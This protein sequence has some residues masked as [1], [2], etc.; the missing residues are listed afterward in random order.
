M[1][2][3][4]GRETLVLRVSLML[5]PMAN[6][7]GLACVRGTVVFSGAKF[8][9]A[10]VGSFDAKFS[11]GTVSFSDPGDLSYPPAFP[12]RARRLHA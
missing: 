4:K 3:Q 12:G 11:G 1:A 9:G 8:S 5:T 10:R 7:V 6:I 2:A